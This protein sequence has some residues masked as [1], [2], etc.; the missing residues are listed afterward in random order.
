MH[1]TEEISLQEL[2]VSSGHEADK[3]SPQYKIDKHDLRLSTD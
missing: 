1:H 3:K 2:G